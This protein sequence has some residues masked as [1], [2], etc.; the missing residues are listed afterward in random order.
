MPS[1]QD[2]SALVNSYEARLQT[3]ENE[4]KKGWVSERVLGRLMTFLRLETD[5]LPLSDSDR[6]TEFKSIDAILSPFQQWTEID[7]R[8]F[9]FMTARGW[10]YSR[11]FGDKIIRE[12]FYLSFFKWYVREFEAGMAPDWAII[13]TMLLDRGLEEDLFSQMM[14]GLDSILT[15]SEGNLSSIG[16]EA[17]KASPELLAHALHTNIR[18]GTGL[19]GSLDSILPQTQED[20]PDIIVQLGFLHP[21]RWKEHP[22]IMAQRLAALHQVYPKQT[23]DLFKQA[24]T[25]PQDSIGFLF[26]AQAYHDVYGKKQ[27]VLDLIAKAL[28]PETNDYWSFYDFNTHQRVTTKEAFFSWIIRTFKEEAKHL[29]INYLSNQPVENSYDFEAEPMVLEAYGQEAVSVIANLLE[30]NPEEGHGSYRSRLAYALIKEYDLSDYEE[31]FW[32]MLLSDTDVFRW[33]GASALQKILGEKDMGRWKNA[34]ASKNKKERMGAVFGLTYQE[35][36]IAKPLLEEIVI[37]E[38]DEPIRNAAAAYVYKHEGEISYEEI[39]KRIAA[40][41]KRGKLKKVSKNWLDEEALGPLFW[42]NGQQLSQRELRYLLYIQKDW[43]PVT[44]HPEAKGIFQKIDT[45]SSSN[46]ASILLNQVQANGGLYA[47]NR[48]A[49]IPIAYL[50]DERILSALQSFSIEKRNPTAASLIGFQK[51]LEAARALDAIM[52]AFKTKYPNVREAAQEAFDQIAQNRGISRFELMDEMIPNLGFD[53]LFRTFEN[54]DKSYRAF[55]GKNLKMQ[56]LDE[57]QK[58]RKSLPASISTDLK[59]EIKTINKSLRELTKGLKERLERALVLQRRWTVEQWKAFFLNKPLPFAMARA[60]V[61]GIYEGEHL[62][63]PFSVTDDQEFEDAAYDEVELPE[64]AAI[65]LIHP[66]ELDEEGRSSWTGYLVENKLT[67]VFPQISRP[68][69][70]LLPEEKELRQLKRFEGKQVKITRFKSRMEKAGWRRGAVMDAGSVENY[71]LELTTANMDA[72]I[73]LENMGVAIYDYE[74]ETTIEELVFVSYDSGKTGEYGT[75][76]YRQNDT[77]LIKPGD[78]PE[79]IMSE[80]LAD[81]FKLFD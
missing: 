12:G 23:A 32:K 40:A 4:V 10:A 5:D 51:S 73:A 9:R 39:E 75:Y 30:K 37:K 67:P 56:F 28:S 80:V 42:Q 50:G 31:L 43:Q 63:A 46:F 52:L 13:E 3:F 77:E 18:S 74:D 34:L 54:K 26:L 8:V 14:E 41:E 76:W 7:H 24:M 66:M 17:A 44:F 20:I 27:E 2:K 62:I 33:I 58:V 25:L 36:A 79:I 6:Y 53:G 70:A 71:F 57:D 11:Q 15:D 16:K 21:R 72:S 65:G 29:V 55:I 45:K 60:L 35:E 19:A 38:K 81:L 78:V 61:W 69:Y 22:A 64:G 47:K 48:F 1:S 59:N 49:L 68:I